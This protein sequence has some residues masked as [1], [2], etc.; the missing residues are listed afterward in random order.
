METFEVRALVRDHKTGRVLFEPPKDDLWLVREK[1]GFG[2]ATKNVFEWHLSFEEY[3]DVYVWEAVPGHANSVL[4][5]RVEEILTR[6]IRCHELKDMYNVCA[7]ILKTVAID[8]KTQ[9]V[10]NIRPGEDVKSLLDW[11]HTHTRA[12]TRSSDNLSQGSIDTLE[13]SYKYTEADEIEDVILFPEEATGE[14]R[15]KLFRANPSALDMFMLEE[16]SDEEIGQAM[17]DNGDKTW[18]AEESYKSELD[19]DY[20]YV[21]ESQIDLDSTI[22]DLNGSFRAAMSLSP[23]NK[24]D[25]FLPLLRNLASASVHSTTVKNHPADLIATLR[26]SLIRQM[27]HDTADESMDADSRRHRREKSRLLKHSWHTAD[28]EPG[29][30]R[31]YT[32]WM[33]MV[34]KMDDFVMS[35]INPGPFELY[36]SMRIAEVFT[37]E[38]R[39]VQDAFEAY[40]SIALFFE[41]DAFLN[42][43]M[44]A[45]FKD[46][47]L[48]DQAERAKHLPDRRT[49]MSNKTMPKVFWEDFEQLRRDNQ[50]KPG[51]VMDDVYPEEWQKA[52]RAIV[53]RW[54]RAGIITRSYLRSAAGIA[55]AKAEPGRP[56]DLYIDFGIHMIPEALTGDVTDPTTV[57]RAWIV[58]RARQFSAEH[59]GARYAILRIWSA[60]HFYP[61][62]LGP[63]S[64][65]KFTFLDDRGRAWMFRAFPKDFPFSEW[66]V[67]LRYS[68]HI[69]PFLPYFGTQVSLAKDL[70][71]VMGKDQK[72]LRRL[73]Q[74][75]TW[76]I[77]TKP[78]RLEVDFWRS[79]VNVDVQ[80][81]EDLNEKWLE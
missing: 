42:S 8:P 34:E 73:S 37:G 59:P 39:C 74:A 7:P 52:I 50:I 31:R 47:K 5:R 65:P 55:T 14:M 3:Y 45:M 81:L 72:D 29:S 43:P 26:S 58:S 24:P 35:E 60:P 46:S 25:Y 57:D 40:A 10:R 54:F 61:Y 44:G 22:E 48:F 69:E 77:Q 51:D 4:Q 17:E 28:M 41:K 71:L 19:S 13:D 79:F 62:E 76:T 63:V 56:M 38:W 1:S 49:Y 16:L 67:H 12:W 80:F 11:A 75:V 66:E 33:I 21:N 78:W 27:D 64:R 68:E 9:R 18:P 2:R 32:E 20:K 6:A 23:S 30:L 15:N 53:I 70:V 36:A